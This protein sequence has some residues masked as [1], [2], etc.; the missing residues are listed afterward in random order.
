MT[1]DLSWLSAYPL[2][3][4]RAQPFGGGLINQTFKIE[5][6]QG[7]F[8]GQQLNT[9][10]FPYP[11]RISTNVRTAWQFLQ[12]KEDSYLF[13][14]PILTQTGQEWSIWEGEYWRLTPFV[15][16]SYSVSVVESPSMAYSAARG[17]GRL[18]RLLDGLDLSTLQE[19]IPQFHYLPMRIQ[20]AQE[21]LQ[22]SSSQRR[23]LAKPLEKLFDRY[24]IIGDYFDRYWQHSEI[25][26]RLLHHDTKISNILFREGTEEV[27]AVCDLDTLMPGIILSDLGDMVRTYACSAH[28]E[29][30][31]W[32]SLQ[33]RPDTYAGLHQGYVQ[34]MSEVL[35]STEREALFWAGP[36][37]FYMQ[38]IRFLADFWLGDPYYKI[39]RPHQNLDRAKNQFI[40]LQQM[41]ENT[42]Y[43]KSLIPS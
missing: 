8:L 41:M 13:L 11:E 9:R 30:T 17:F 5:T 39:T 14:A 33:V 20:Q 6:D 28:E 26:R 29:N 34:E 12:K 23:Q 21:A 1:Q 38:A 19:T 4:R 10:V 27:L 32:S 16:H 18:T 36:S 43:W 25:P 2:E 40:L 3:V 15:P 42:S 7:T 22:Q 24:Q 31:E 37:L 35:T